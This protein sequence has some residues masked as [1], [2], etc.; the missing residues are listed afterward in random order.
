[1]SPILVTLFACLGALVPLATFLG[2]AVRSIVRAA[3]TEQMADMR[4]TFVQSAGATETGAEWN[5]RYAEL[6]EDVQ[7]LRQWSEAGRGPVPAASKARR[8]APRIMA[9]G[10]AAGY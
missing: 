5:R 7:E 4:A 9:A 1:M 6:R 3:N 2:W 8:A 10:A